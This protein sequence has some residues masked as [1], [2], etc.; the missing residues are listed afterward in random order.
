M[1]RSSS[2][3]R[4]LHDLGAE[5]I[6]CDVF[7]QSA[8]TSVLCDFQP[9]TVIHQL[10]DLPDDPTRLRYSMAATARIRTEGTTNLVAASESAGATQ[11]VAQSV[12]WLTSDPITF[13][14]QTVLAAHGV[15]LRYGQWYGTGTYFE[16]DQLPPPPRV[17]IDAAAAQTVSALDRPPGIYVVSDA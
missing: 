13:L 14:E 12:A 5:P 2:K 16:G 11:V 8:L 9:H 17:H 1:T 6:V 15:V 3:V 7:D 4:Q 10:T